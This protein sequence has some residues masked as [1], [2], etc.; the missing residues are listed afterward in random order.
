M[1]ACRPVCSAAGEVWASLI[2][3]RNNAKVVVWVVMHCA[4]AQTLPNCQ[5]P[6]PAAA[7]RRRCRCQPPLP[8]LPQ[9][10]EVE[11]NTGE[12]YSY[13]AE[14]LRVESPAEEGIRDAAGRLKV[15]RTAAAAAALAHTHNCAPPA[16]LSGDLPPTCARTRAC[17]LCMGGGTSESWTFSR[18]AATP[19][20]ER[21]AVW[22]HGLDTSPQKACCVLTAERLFPH[23]AVA[24]SSSMT[25]TRM[26]SIPGLCC[27]RWGAR[28]ANGGA[29]GPI[30][31]A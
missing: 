4:E 25:C 1:L 15:Q 28:R 10:L 31:S 17:R 24:G 26:A 2:T 3:L 23:Q 9:V 29:C 12:R 22:R 14:Y 7:S 30:C 11:F 18:W 5:P 19:C 13:S 6:P 16:P 27:A 20:G 8:P 21:R